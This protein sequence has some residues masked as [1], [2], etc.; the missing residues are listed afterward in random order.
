MLNW[1]FVKI[2]YLDPAKI[3]CFFKTNIES[4]SAATLQFEELV[5]IRVMVCKKG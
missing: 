5:I 4:Y 2:G 3:V 1:D